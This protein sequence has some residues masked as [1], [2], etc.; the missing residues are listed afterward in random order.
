[1][2]KYK[3]S[4]MKAASM[5]IQATRDTFILPSDVQNL[6][7]KRAEE[8]YQRHKND[9]L[10]VRMWTEENADAVFFF[11]EHETIDLNQAP[12]LECT[13]TLGIQTDW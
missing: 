5:G 8:L 4:V 10:S 13:Y 11:Q 6:A 7:K 3:E 12:Q 2:A 9:A 1:M